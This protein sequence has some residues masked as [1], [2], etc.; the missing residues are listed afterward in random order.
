MITLPNGC[1]CSEINVSPSNWNKVGASIHKTRRIHY[2]FYDPSMYK[3]YQVIIEAEINQI[4][5]LAERRLLL[6]TQ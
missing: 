4:K 1:H 5:D 3:P 6:K 2:R